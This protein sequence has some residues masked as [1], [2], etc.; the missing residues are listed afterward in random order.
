MFLQTLLAVL[1]VIVVVVVAGIWWVKRWIARAVG[2]HTAAAELLDPSLLR[3]ARMHLQ[4]ARQLELG[5]EA[6]EFWEAAGKLGFRKL[7]D[8]DGNVC[9]RAGQHVSLPLLVAVV[10]DDQESAHFTCF[11]V[12]TERTLTAVTSEPGTSI[13]IG[14]LHWHAE[15]DLTMAEALGRLQEL[16]K[17]RTLLK[18][19]AGQC[20]AACEQSHAARMDRLLAVPP[21]RE[22]IVDGGAAD[23]ERTDD[24]LIDLAFALATCHWREQVE[25]AARDH[26]L[27]KSELDAIDWERIKDDVHVVHGHLDE[28]DID[29]MLVDDE[30]GEQIL[31][32]MVDQGLQGV[33]LYEQ[34]LARLPAPAHREKL[35]EVSRP[36]RAVIYGPTD[37]PGDSAGKQYLYQANDGDRKV[38]GAVVATSA[39]DAKRQLTN[40]GLTQSALLCDPTPL[41]DELEFDWS[42][43]E[44]A[45]VAARSTDESVVVAALR[46]LVSTGWIWGPPCALLVWTFLDGAPFGLGDYVVMAYAGAAAVAMVFLVAP[47]IVYDLFL[48]ARVNARWRAARF[49]IA[50]L[51][52]INTFSG[53]G[54]NLL[55]LERLKIVAAQG[56]DDSALRTWE[57]RRADMSEAEYQ[58]GLSMLYDA[59]GDH[60]G[61]IRAQRAI[62]QA[63]TGGHEMPSVDLAMS[64]A[65]FDGA[66]EAEALLS[67]IAP[68]DLTELSAAAYHYSRGLIIASRES[69]EQALPLYGRAMQLLE[70]YSSNPLVTLFVAE[71]NARAAISLKEIGEADEANALWRRAWSVL[72]PHR[73]TDVLEARFEAC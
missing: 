58:G 11:A 38:H 37:E 60:E 73:G 56:N 72:R 41:D 48:R 36:L 2:E 63:E 61:M 33:E 31:R 49:L 18:L 44:A 67:G 55:L 4:P 69:H 14:K 40:I 8:F 57:S 21:R 30:V 23:S 43:R 62:V 65:R 59:M 50:L 70:T 34:V 5:D 64:L 45:R 16:T 19:T 51:S 12:D 47:M 54:A 9:V 6:S 68:Q 1:L 27:R 52:K 46:S 53:L 66:D 7:A 71:I 35:G 17:E 26:F 25:E 24:K 39:G 28:G 42:D 32:Q 15:P 22:Q 10:E 13:Q 29:N 3:P 20:R